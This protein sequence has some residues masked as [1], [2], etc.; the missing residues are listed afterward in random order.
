VST[1]G[2]GLLGRSAGTV[3]G[4]I[5]QGALG[6]PESGASFQYGMVVLPGFDS[7]VP[8][9]N[10]VIDI[11]GNLVRRVAVGLWLAHARDVVVRGNELHHVGMGLALEG[12]LRSRVAGNDVLA[13][14]VGIGVTAGSKANRI[15]DNVLTGAGGRCTDDT[16][17]WRTAGTANDWSGN[18]A[19]QA[20]SP[21]GICPAG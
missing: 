6:A 11:R 8:A 16:T 2:I 17:G 21:G 7:S 14:Q 12:A 19:T 1:F 9:R 10:G 20:G 18:S 4:N 15:A 13:L 3:R 5:V